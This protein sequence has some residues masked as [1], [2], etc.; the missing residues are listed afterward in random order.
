MLIETKIDT[1]TILKIV[2]AAQLM[3]SAG[4]SQECTNILKQLGKELCKL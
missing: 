4:K 3:Q 1:G 2:E